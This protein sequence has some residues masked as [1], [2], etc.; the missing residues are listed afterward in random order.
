MVD[1]CEEYEKSQ[2]LDLKD[3]A[4]LSH[5]TKVSQGDFGDEK[6]SQGDIFIITAGAKQREEESRLDL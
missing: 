3:L 1:L 2:T 4:S 6:V 5:R